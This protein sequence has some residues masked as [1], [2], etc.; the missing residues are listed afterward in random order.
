MR[1]LIFLL[2]LLP[3]AAW[4]NTSSAIY[5]AAPTTDCLQSVEQRIVETF[6]RLFK[7]QG[8]S[9][10]LKPQGPMLPEKTLINSLGQSGT[11]YSLMAHYPEQALSIVR[12]EGMTI[13][14]RMRI[15]IRPGSIFRYS[16]M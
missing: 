14:M 5:C 8:E 15:I 13:W 12:L 2:G 3:A 9:L 11:Q 1:Q 4:A 16:V 7:R 6:P 10:V